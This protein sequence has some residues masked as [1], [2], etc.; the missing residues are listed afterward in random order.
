MAL[1]QHIFG[2]LPDGRRVIQFTLGSAR[3]LQVKIINFGAAVS[4]LCFPDKNGMTGEITAGFAQLEPYTLNH[5]HFGVVV[6]RY[7]NRIAGGKFQIDGLEY[8]LTRN[9]KKHHLHGGPEGFHKKLWNYKTEEANGIEQ[10]KLSY[11]SK[12]LEEG[13]P[14]RLEVEVIYR[15]EQQNR[16]VVEFLAQTDRPCPVNLTSHMYFNLSGFTEDIGTHQLRLSSE[17]YLE[18]SADQIPSGRYLNCSPG[19]YD[20]S[21]GKILKNL[22]SGLEPE[23]DH[24][25]V[26]NPERAVHE[27]AAELWHGPS[28]RRLRLYTDQ[29]GLQVYTGNSLDGSFQGHHRRP[30]QRHDA[31]C[32]EPQLYPDSPNQP[33]FPNSL[34]LPGEK[35]SHKSQFLFDHVF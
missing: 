17:K 28:G 12:H 30:Y 11:T 7:A 21:K 5:P 27:A 9:D 18:T 19:H 31:I 24:C 16:L 8:Q 15:L 29:P 25:F 32:L 4:S 10:V 2:I 26:L 22:I 20:F 33:E 6:G 3:G 35:Y 34:L 23:V 1:R 13:Y 14:G